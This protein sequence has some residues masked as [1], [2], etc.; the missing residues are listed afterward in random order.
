MFIVY[1]MKQLALFN[2]FPLSPKWAGSVGQSSIPA[3]KIATVKQEGVWCILIDSGL[4]DDT[5]I[6]NKNKWH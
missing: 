2:V 3:P 4:N 5:V 6:V 1:S